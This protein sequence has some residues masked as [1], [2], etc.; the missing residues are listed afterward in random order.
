VQAPAP[1]L[2]LPQPDPMIEM[3]PLQEV[4]LQQGGIRR[5]TRLAERSQGLYSN[6]LEKALKKKREESTSSGTSKNPKAT[7]AAKQDTA[8]TSAVPHLLPDKLLRMG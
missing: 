7:R 4:P 1:G 8:S 2:Q 3:V 5:S 6:V